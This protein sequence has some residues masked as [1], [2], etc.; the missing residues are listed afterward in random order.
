MGM[1]FYVRF[2]RHRFVDAFPI[3]LLGSARPDFTIIAIDCRGA[4]SEPGMGFLS[5]FVLSR[6]D[7]ERDNG[8][9]N[10]LFTPVLKINRDAVVDRG[11]YLTQP[12]IGLIRMTDKRT[13]HQ[14]I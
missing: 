13:G 2:S 11:L 8:R 12:P 5:L 9:V 7:Y 3:G 14:L 6:H 4:K 1:F 10:Q